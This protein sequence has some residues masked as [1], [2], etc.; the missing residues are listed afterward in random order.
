MEKKYEI[1]TNEL[2]ID[3]RKFFQIKSLRGFGSIV[4]GKLGG[5][6]EG[7]HNLSQEGTC[8]IDSGVILMDNARVTHDTFVSGN[9]FIRGNAQVRNRAFVLNTT[10]CDNAVVEGA[11]RVIGGDHDCDRIVIKDDAVVSGNIHGSLVVCGNAHIRG[12]IENHIDI[13][14]GTDTN[15]ID[16]L[17]VY[18]AP[19][20][21]EYAYTAVIV[22]YKNK[23][24]W[25]FRHEDGIIE[26]TSREIDSLLPELVGPKF[27][28]YM[29]LIRD[30]HHSIYN[31]E[32]FNDDFE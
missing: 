21:T 14:V 2:T 23:D 32:L 18:P 3:G 27:A 4:A 24:A 10:V 1:T 11:A 29:K 13:W 9:S 17:V 26:V 16:Q 19:K 31:I 30:A 20:D 7:E 25:G 5:Y 8:W 22:T 6:V 12:I 15:G 28:N